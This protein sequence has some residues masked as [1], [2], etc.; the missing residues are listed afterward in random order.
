MTFYMRQEFEANCQV[1][2]TFLPHSARAFS[3]CSSSTI[4][5]GS[6]SAEFPLKNGHL[7]VYWSGIVKTMT[8]FAP[9]GT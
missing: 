8:S 1:V 2:K 6:V 3:F 4:N 9:G 5:R 7:R